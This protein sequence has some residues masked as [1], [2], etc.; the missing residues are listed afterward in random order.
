MKKWANELK[1]ALLKEEVQM[2]KNQHS[3]PQ[4]KWKSKPHK[5][6]T[7]LLLE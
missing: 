4:G 2:V 1:R 5:D 7:S 6:P 3:W